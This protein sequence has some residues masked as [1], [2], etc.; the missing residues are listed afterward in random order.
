VADPTPLYPFPNAHDLQIIV[1][2]AGMW[3]YIGPSMKLKDPQGRFDRA[4][5]IMFGGF[6]P[7]LSNGWKGATKLKFKIQSKGGKSVQIDYLDV[8][9]DMLGSTTYPFTV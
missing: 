2:R 3:L 4:N 9:G 5:L 7:N 1:D 6:V 8:N